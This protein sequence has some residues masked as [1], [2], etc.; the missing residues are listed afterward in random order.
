MVKNGE[1]ATRFLSVIWEAWTNEVC[2]C[3][4]FLADLRPESLGLFTAIFQY[5]TITR[6]TLEGHEI[7][8]VQVKPTPEPAYVNNKLYVR[9][10]AQSKELQGP[11]LVRYVRKRWE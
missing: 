4:H 1:V 8:Q 2:N 7:A 6:H 5:L 10:G 9:A 11:D 3:T